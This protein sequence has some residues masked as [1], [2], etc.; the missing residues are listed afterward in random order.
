MGSPVRWVGAFGLWSLLVWGTRVDN[1]WSDAGL[2][3]G[4]QVGRTAL[5]LSFVLPAV[6]V[7]ALLVR[8]ATWRSRRRGLPPCIWYLLGPFAAWTVAVW[9][10]R[11]GGIL[12]DD[13]GVAFKVVH[14]LLAVA[15][16]ALA[17]QAWRSL[18]SGED[19]ANGVP[20]A[21]PGVQYTHEK[22][23]GFDA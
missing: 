15:S 22:G 16:I 2:S 9:V 18:R 21:R 4:A 17:V 7:L 6:L 10:V 11:G 23:S 8:A 14:T 19:P 5:A 3:T 12:L 13:H 20:I 1:I